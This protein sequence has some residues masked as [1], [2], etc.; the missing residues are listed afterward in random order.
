MHFVG[1]NKMKKLKLKEMKK[2]RAA[3]RG[4]TGDGDCKAGETCQK[5]TITAWDVSLC[6]IE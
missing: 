6:M 3:M 4:C 1:G 2:I 5:L